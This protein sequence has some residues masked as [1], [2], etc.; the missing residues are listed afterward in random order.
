MMVKSNNL[1]TNNQNMYNISI[2]FNS[3]ILKATSNTNDA[4]IEK[5]SSINQIL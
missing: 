5:Q 3:I 2:P 4:I 1:S